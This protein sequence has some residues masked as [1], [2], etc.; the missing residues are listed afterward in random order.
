MDSYDLSPDGLRNTFKLL[1]DGGFL[2]RGDLTGDIST[3]HEA[4]D[5]GAVRQL[6]RYYLDFDLPIIQTGTSQVEGRVR[7]LSEKGV[8]AR[9]IPAEVDETK[10]LLI[11]HDKFFL[12]KPFSFQAKCKWVKAGDKAHDYVAGFQIVEI[13]EEADENLKKL[14]RMLTFAASPRRSWR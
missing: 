11:R 6:Q 9:G 2:D 10:T 12:L 5:R 8:G 1:L 7:D 13:S 14:V 3:R 4:L